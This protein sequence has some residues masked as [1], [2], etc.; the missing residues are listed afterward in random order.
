[1]IEADVCI[2][3]S[4]AGGAILAYE[5]VRAGRDV[6]ILG[7]GPYVQPHEFSEDEVAMIGQLYGDGIMQQTTDFRFTVLQGS[8][9]RR[10]D[11]RAIRVQ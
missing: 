3:G 10:L 7:E 2:V 8:V 11:D 6:L 5:P 4:G 1:M 9:R